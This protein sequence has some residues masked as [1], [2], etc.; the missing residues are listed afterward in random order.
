MLVEELQHERYIEILFVTQ[1]ELIKGPEGIN[2]CKTWDNEY[3]AKMLY[4]GKRRVFQ[5]ESSQGVTPEKSQLQPEP[6][7][8][9]ERREW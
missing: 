3:Y 9:R 7:H 8:G 4:Q 5:I 1:E 2:Y 6:P